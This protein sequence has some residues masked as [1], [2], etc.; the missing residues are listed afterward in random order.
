MKILEGSFSKNLDS[1]RKEKNLSLYEFAVRIGRAKNLV[2]AWAK[3]EIALAE[4]DIFYMHR[5]L[6]LVDENILHYGNSD[7]DFAEGFPFRALVSRGFLDK[8]SNLP[9]HEQL[10]QFFQIGSKS[11]FEKAYLSSNSPIVS[12][13]FSE[14]DFPK[15]YAAWYRCGELLDA[16]EEKN[17]FSAKGLDILRKKLLNLSYLKEEN[18]LEKALELCKKFGISLV[19]VPS[20]P[21]AFSGSVGVFKNSKPLLIFSERYANEI[22][23]LEML[24]EALEFFETEKTGMF[25]KDIAGL[26]ENQEYKKKADDKL[27]SEFRECQILAVGDY[28]E[29]A[30]KFFSKEFKLPSAIIARR[31]Q[32]LNRMGYYGKY[33]NIF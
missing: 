7:Q 10:F 31:L 5:V 20:F 21:Q 24:F 26:K 14:S 11:A 28:S 25:V 16:K 9:K 19:F 3:A 22:L 27:L 15:I 17:L 29:R 2:Y 12:V 4:L 8:D 6:G 1:V 23:F 30:V 32:K 18:F 13:D 33:R